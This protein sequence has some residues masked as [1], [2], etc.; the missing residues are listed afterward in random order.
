[1]NALP[2]ILAL[3]LAA[4][5][6]PPAIRPVWL[7][8]LS[9]FTGP[10]RSQWAS[11]S[12]DRSREETFVTHAGVVGIYNKMGMEVFEFG[13]DGSLGFVM[14]SAVLD[15][16]DQVVLSSVEGRREMFLCDYRGEPVGRFELSG[17][18]P[19]LQK[20]FEPDLITARD[21]KIYLASSGLL[22][23]V[24]ADPSGKVLAHHNLA[25]LL[26]LDERGAD[27]ASF[28]GMGVDREGRILLTMP[29]MFKVAIVSPNGTVRTFG[30]RG[31]VPGKFNII[32]KMDS[33]ERGYYFLT[34]ILRSV[35][36]VFD[37]N[38]EF[39]GE[40]GY[41]GEDPDNLISPVDIV[42]ANG[43]VYVAQA[44]N[45]GVSVF[46][47]EITPPAPPPTSAPATPPSTAAPR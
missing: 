29:L 21:G 35:V 1:V 7:Y 15:D 23:V 3:A 25:K 2:I 42:A 27:T 43:K 38:I 14:A 13:G 5:P 20:K 30:Q 6:P 32:G 33:D 10:V 17:L 41:R 11:L 39:L 26:K 45:R 37:P 47:V 19:A 12:F 8:N 34:D 16:G 4:D 31:S 36:M 44:G 28:R 18:P 22:D 9:D 46:R 24:V 40:F